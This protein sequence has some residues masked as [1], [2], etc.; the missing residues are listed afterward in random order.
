MPLRFEATLQHTTVS[1]FRSGSGVAMLLYKEG[2][3]GRKEKKKKTEKKKNHPCGVWQQMYEKADKV[4]LH[5][6]S[7][8]ARTARDL[9]RSW[10]EGKKKKKG[11][12]GTLF[13]DVSSYTR[14]AGRMEEEDVCDENAVACSERA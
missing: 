6:P 8:L 1:L 5:Q 7:S 9:R 14:K 3:H 13:N 2:W 4:L 12:L 10:T 11:R